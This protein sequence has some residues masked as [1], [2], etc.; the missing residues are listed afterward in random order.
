[1]MACHTA[2]EVRHALYEDEVML[3]GWNDSQQNGHTAKFWIA[4]DTMGHPFEGIDRKQELIVSLVEL[5][6]DNEPID[7]KMRDRVEGQ[8]VHPQSRLSVACAALCRNPVFWAWLERNPV[9][10]GQIVIKDDYT[11]TQVMRGYLRVNSR[12][13]LDDPANEAAIEKFHLVRKQFAE[14]Q[15]DPF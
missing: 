1:M 3:A 2:G 4:S 13:E 9:L 6:D 15:G 5:D 7:Q 11:C 10:T 12:A 8:K 14:S